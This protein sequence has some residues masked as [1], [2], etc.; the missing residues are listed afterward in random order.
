M[1]RAKN[2]WSAT[3]ER[4]DNPDGSGVEITTA[5]T[6]RELV[7]IITCNHCDERTNVIRKHGVGRYSYEA[8]NGRY[9]EI[10][11]RSA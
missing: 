7:W 1:S 6:K 2:E 9:Y 10:T 5:A 4:W 8:P 11:S 3:S